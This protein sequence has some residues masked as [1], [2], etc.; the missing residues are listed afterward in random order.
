MGT[1]LGTGLVVL[2]LVAIVFAIVFSMIK[3]KKKGKSSCGGVCCHCPNSAM[4][5]SVQSKKMKPHSCK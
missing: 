4:C 5:H 1:V 2:I 3:D